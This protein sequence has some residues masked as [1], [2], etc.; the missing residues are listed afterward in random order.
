VNEIG[1]VSIRIG[2]EPTSAHRRIESPAALR[3]VLASWAADSRIDLDAIPA[4]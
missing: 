1:G 3:R 4:A 2:R